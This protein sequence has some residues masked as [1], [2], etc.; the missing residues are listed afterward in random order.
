MKG[1]D[2]SKWQ[3][4]IDWNA[5]RNAGY[6]FAILKTG[7]SDDGFYTDPYFEINYRNATAAGMHVGAYYY[8]GSACTSGPDGAADAKRFLAMLSGKQFDMPV[9]ID[10]EEPNAS[11]PSGNTDA[12]IE[13]CKVMEAAG[14]YAGVYGSD[15]S[16]F[17]DKLQ[18]SR[19][20]PYTWWVAHYGAARPDYATENAGVFQYSNKGSVP[21]ISGRVDLDDGYVDYPS[22][23]SSGGFNGYGKGSTPAQEQSTPSASPSAPAPSQTSSGFAVGDV[24]KVA[25]AVTYDGAPFKLWYT[26]YTVMEVSGDRVVIGIGGQVTAAVNAANLVK[27]STGSNPSSGSDLHVGDQ[28]RVTHTVTYDGRRFTVWYDTYTVMEITGDRV[29]IGV[30]GTVTAAVK[31]SSVQKV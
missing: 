21:G 4:S 24:V 20:L 14:Y 27:V 17:Q 18:K 13:F 31:R 19:L 29:V 22:T 16:G 2:V 26:K 11:N 15:Y 1:I 5:V 25:N 7:G 6:E 12:C 28:V 30:N 23:I 9:Y 8:V 3:G 10:F